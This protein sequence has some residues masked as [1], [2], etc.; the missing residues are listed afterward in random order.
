[1]TKHQTFVVSPSLLNYN[2][3]LKLTSLDISK[4]RSTNQNN[5]LFRGN[6]II[7]NFRLLGI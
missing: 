5:E 3:K 7:M 6:S 2:A 1:M 4:Q